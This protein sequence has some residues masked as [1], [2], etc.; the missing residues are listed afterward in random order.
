MFQAAPVAPIEGLTP[1]KIQ[2]ARNRVAVTF[3]HNKMQIIGHS[4]VD[5]RKELPRQIGPAPFARSGIL[6]KGPKGIPVF[7]ADL[8]SGVAMD[9]AAKALMAQLETK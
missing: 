9:R 4:L 6:I 1:D 8:V 2:R 7:G 3:R 5:D